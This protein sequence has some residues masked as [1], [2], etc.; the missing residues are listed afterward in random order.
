MIIKIVI[1]T[2]MIRIIIITVMSITYDCDLILIS[3]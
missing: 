3:I 1:L 2:V